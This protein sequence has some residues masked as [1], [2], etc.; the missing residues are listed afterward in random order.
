MHYNY[1]IYIQTKILLSNSLDSSEK[2]L[3]F[4]F[5]LLRKFVPKIYKSIVLK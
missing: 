3:Q 4:F 2:G 5:Y 1:N